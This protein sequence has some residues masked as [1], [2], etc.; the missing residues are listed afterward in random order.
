MYDPS[1]AILRDGTGS[2]AHYVSTL[3]SATVE[4][5]PHRRLGFSLVYTH[6][7][8]GRF[9]RKTGPHEPIDF[10]EVTA[11]IRF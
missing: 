9:V 3:V 4:W 2:D 5:Q 1:G 8:P 7:V 10:V 6:V 11:R